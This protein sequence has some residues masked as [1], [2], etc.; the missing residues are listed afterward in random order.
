MSYISK[1]YFLIMV[2]T[3]IMAMPSI[4]RAEEENP[5]AAAIA[6]P[7]NADRCVDLNRLDH[8]DIVEDG[9]ILFY[10]RHKKIYLNVL[11]HACPGLKSADT[12]MYRLSIYRLCDVDV[13]TVLNQMGGGFYPGASCGLGLFYPIDEETAKQLTKR[14]Q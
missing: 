14:S 4:T 9:F 10:M 6:N 13:I 2:S 12:F 5:L 11:P 3:G 8:T 1:I 7:D